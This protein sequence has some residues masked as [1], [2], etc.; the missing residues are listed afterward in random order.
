MPRLSRTS[1]IASASV[2]KSLP[3]GTALDPP[4]T[5]MNGVVPSRPV[6]VGR[7]SGDADVVAAEDEQA[8]AGPGRLPEPQVVPQQAGVTQVVRG[9]HQRPSR[10]G[11]TGSDQLSVT[12]DVRAEPWMRALGPPSLVGVQERCKLALNVRLD[13]ACGLDSII[14]FGFRCDS[15]GKPK[16]I[17]L[18][19]LS[20][21]EERDIMGG[22]GAAG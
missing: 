21:I 11:D 4:E 9:W 18:A 2:V 12:V 13:L 19:A 3:S 22:R 10:S 7:A 5:T 16:H 1:A 6:Q 15:T 20:P 17:K 14:C 8:P